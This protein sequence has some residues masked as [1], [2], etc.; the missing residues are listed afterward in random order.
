MRYCLST[1]GSA[2]YI[3]PVTLSTADTPVF[4]YTGHRTV[5]MYSDAV[6]E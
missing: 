4:P 2:E 1:A 5:N 3:L 6:I